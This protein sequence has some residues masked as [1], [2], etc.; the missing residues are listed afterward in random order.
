M[1]WL[2]RRLLS[3]SVGCEVNPSAAALD[4]YCTGVAFPALCITIVRYADRRSAV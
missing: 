2:R 3:A 4:M 1:Q